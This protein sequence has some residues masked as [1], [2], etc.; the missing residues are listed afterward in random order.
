MLSIRNIG[1]RSLGV[2]Q[3]LTRSFALSVPQMQQQAQP[4]KSHSDN[5]LNWEQF[6]A[7]RKS[8]RRVNLVTS[9]FSALFASSAS[10]G[11]ISQIEMNP[12]ELIFGIDPFMA[13]AIGMMGASV[14]GYLLGPLF[15]DGIFNLRHRKII[16][17]FTEKQKVFLD[18]IKK[19]RVDATRQSVANPVPDYYGEK[20]GSLKEYRQWLRDCNSYRR[21]AREF[22]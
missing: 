6:L 1:V 17:E 20:I 8:Q 13:S 12:T 7:L 19:N 3:M 9:I 2:N 14:L 21:R 15:G 22:V 4:Q 18:R 10:W 5:P 16:H 11:Y